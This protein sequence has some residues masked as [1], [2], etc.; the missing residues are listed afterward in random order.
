[1]K[2]INQYIRVCFGLLTGA[3]ALVSTTGVAADES[4]TQGWQAGGGLYFWG[5]SIG[6]K[7][8]TGSDIDIGIDKLIRNL[9]MA[10]MGELTARKDKLTLGLDAIY[11]N[12]GAQNDRKIDFPVDQGSVQ[13]PLKAEVQMKA[14]V[15]TPSIRY[16]VIE[17][18]KGSLDVLAGARYLY[19]GAEL[20]ATAKGPIKE[21][22]QKIIRLR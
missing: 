5:A 20:K 7:S 21:R 4:L 22:T 14:W 19:L 17:N 15:V 18:E 8:V 11:F 13:I 3:S 1:M 2:S 12:V 16:N 9:N 6:G 10:F